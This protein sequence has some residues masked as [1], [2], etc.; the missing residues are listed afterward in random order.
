MEL[1][2]G[3]QLH[4]LR[5]EAGLT[6]EQLA[7]AMGVTT[8]A[9]HK[10]ETGKATP[11]LGLLVELAEF[12][13]TSVDALLNYGWQKGSMGKAAETL[14]QMLEEKRLEEGIRYAEKALQKYP[15][16]FQVVWESGE[17]YFIAMVSSGQGKARAWRAVELYRRAMELLDQNQNPDI[18]LLTIQNRVASCY[19]YLDRQKEAVE[20]LRENN[21]EG[22]NDSMIGLLLSQGKQPQEALP[23]LSDALFGCHAMI[24]R[25]CIG[26]VNAY[27]ALGKYRQ[28]EELVRWLLEMG[29]GLQ[30]P[31]VVSYQDK[32]NVRLYTILA[33][34]ALWQG[35]EEQAC[36]WLETARQ[37]AL[38]FDR[39]PQFRI[40][41]GKKFYHGSRHTMAYDDMGETAMASIEL[42]LADPEAGKG[43]VPLWEKIRRGGDRETGEEE[44]V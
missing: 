14:R 39:T 32:S 15:N 12:F 19:C 22:I 42:F 1:Q 3:T 25:T 7:E 21:V 40:C 38:R 35:K 5:K 6:Q 34:L 28:A 18:S 9:V 17:L 24:Y 16:S 27:T 8:G 33:A 10:W 13:E 2:L 37:T 26:Y 43:L 41:V 44:E 30:E 4:R 36:Q 11:E 20:L 23:Y 29:K 31:N